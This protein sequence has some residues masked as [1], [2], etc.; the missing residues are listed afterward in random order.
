[1]VA[2]VAVE[3]VIIL[4]QS[5]AQVLQIQEAVEAQVMVLVVTVL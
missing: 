3:L 4:T 1:M 5:V 2:M